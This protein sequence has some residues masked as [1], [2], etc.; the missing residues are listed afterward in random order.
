MVT[1]WPGSDPV[2]SMREA[3]IAQQGERQKILPDPVT[4]K[5]GQRGLF[6]KLVQSHEEFQ[7]NPVCWQRRKPDFPHG[8]RNSHN[9]PSV[10]NL[11]MILN[12]DFDLYRI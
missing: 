7:R 1:P 3:S 8:A 12:H 2:N 11:K 9:V 5:D 4:V 6:P 10:K